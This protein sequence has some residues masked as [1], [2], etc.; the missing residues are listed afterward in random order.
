VVF[1]PVGEDDRFDVLAVLSEIADIGYDDVNAQELFFGKHQAGIDDD[2]V[3]LPPE[4]HAVHAEL[5]KAPERD[6]A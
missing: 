2:N 1:V 4:G 5:A 6:H 3:I